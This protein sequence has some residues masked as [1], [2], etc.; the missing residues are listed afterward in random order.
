MNIDY[1]NGAIITIPGT[2]EV[3][4]IGSRRGP[5]HVGTL[6]CAIGT[7]TVRDEW[8]KT[9]DPGEYNGLF[10]VSE[11]TLYSYHF[12]GE[13]R[14]AIRA[15]IDSWRLDCDEDKWMDADG[16][17]AFA[18]DAGDEPLAFA[19]DIPEAEA[20][21]ESADIGEY[22]DD[23]VLLLRRYH[24]SDDGEIWRYGDD[25]RIDSTIG[26]ENIWQCRQ[27]LVALGYQLNTKA[28]TWFL[29]DEEVA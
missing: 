22:E 1:D 24:A 23:N 26:R 21:E 7:F 4:E 29:A 6:T 5:F 8:L 13:N 19:D 11:I 3:R 17:V 10:D 28:R 9:F 27:A 16:D 12:C 25:Y 15:V 14:T 20:E 18:D 2:L